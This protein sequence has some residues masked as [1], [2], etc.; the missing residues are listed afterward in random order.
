MKPF[1]MIGLLT[2]M[3]MASVMTWPAT[4]MAAG[5]KDKIMLVLP[6]PINDQDWNATAYAGL[7][8]VKK[9]LGVKMQYIE[10]IKTANAEA[11]LT[12]LGSKNYQLVIATEP[13]TTTT[14]R[15]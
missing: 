5:K 6:G 10:N 9:K 1:R 15:S 7:L 14:R 2:A 12:D 13:S 4:S 8:Q 3:V 11:T